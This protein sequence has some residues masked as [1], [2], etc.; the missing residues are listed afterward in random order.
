MLSARK[1]GAQV[2]KL[3]EEGYLLQSLRRVLMGEISLSGEG[4]QTSDD[5]KALHN[6][7]NEYSRQVLLEA[8][9]ILLNELNDASLKP[10]LASSIHEFI[11]ESTR[12]SDEKMVHA[13]RLVAGSALTLRYMTLKLTPIADE[14]L[15]NAINWMTQE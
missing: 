14:T 6:L 1:Y 15:K 12:W 4:Y 13:I 10:Q 11:P 3:R 7:P 5:L 9:R 8:N 2:R